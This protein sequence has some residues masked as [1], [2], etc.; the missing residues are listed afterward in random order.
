MDEERKQLL[1]RIVEA[2]ARRQLASI[3]ILGHCLK[4]VTELDAKVSVAGELDLSLRLFRQVH[5][6]Y[7]DL[8]WTD[9]ESAV[10]DRL[11][12]VPYPASRLEF[13]VAYYVTGLAEEVAMR[14][15]VT[16]SC[17]EFAA[18]ARSYV[19]AAQ[20]RPEPRRFLA[21]CEDPE[22]RPQAR[23]FF[24]LWYRIAVGALGRKDSTADARVVEL[25][26]RSKSAGQMVAE[27]D[28]RL[29]PFLEAC[30]LDGRSSS[31]TAG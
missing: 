6:L 1:R 24:D 18:I 4:F 19:E 17:P 5:L 13:G 21:Y 12:D 31:E 29:A 30:G 3:N 15:Y 28:E 2:M 11:E 14:S 10:R 25:G 9:L 26:L 23:Q 8:G 7:R 22:H 27:F 20:R 16:S